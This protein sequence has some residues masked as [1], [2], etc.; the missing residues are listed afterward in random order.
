M[1]KDRSVIPA[2]RGLTSLPRVRCK[3]LIAVANDAGVHLVAVETAAEAV[4]A[5]EHRSG[6]YID[7]ALGLVDLPGSKEGRVP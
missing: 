7:A 6:L 1:P 2:S 3:L 4:L 5:G